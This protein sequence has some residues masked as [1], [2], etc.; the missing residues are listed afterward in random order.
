MA[1]T[2]AQLINIQKGL[3]KT[4]ATLEDESPEWKFLLEQISSMDILITASQKKP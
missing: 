4:K 2:T 3:K 1:H